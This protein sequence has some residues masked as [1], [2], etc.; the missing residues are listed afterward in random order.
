MARTD[1]T[2]PLW[3]RL[4]HGDLTSRPSHAQHGPHD[5]DLPPRPSRGRTRCYWQFVWTGT[6]VCSCW[7]C[8]GKGWDR[9]PGKIERQSKRRAIREQVGT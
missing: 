9:K 6:R 3:V 2:A 7:L 5:C 1:K 8:S 4:A